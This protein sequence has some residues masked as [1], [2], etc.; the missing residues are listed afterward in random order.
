MLPWKIQSSTL[1]R[2]SAILSPMSF[3]QLLRCG[4]VFR[5]TGRKGIVVG[6][7][8]TYVN[9]LYVIVYTRQHYVCW[10]QVAIYNVMAVQT[11]QSIKQLSEEIVKIYI[12]TE[13]VWVISQLLFYRLPRNVF[14]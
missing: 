14:G 7:A 10:L 6:I 12:V 1:T 8:E 3:L 4:V 9:N 13:V 2:F 11:A 5:H